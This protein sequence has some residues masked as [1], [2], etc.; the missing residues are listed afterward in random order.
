MYL[1]CIFLAVRV[2]LGKIGRPGEGILRVTELFI[3]YGTWTLVSLKAYLTSN[4]CYLIYVVH[5]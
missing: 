5:V 2:L 3:W 1:A 4:V